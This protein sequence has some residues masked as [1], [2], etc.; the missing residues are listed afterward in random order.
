VA[1]NEFMSENL[2]QLNMTLKEIEY[3]REKN[4]AQELGISGTPAIAIFKNGD[5]IR[6]YL[7][8]LTT[9]ELSVMIREM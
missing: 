1:I 2:G 9:E 8:E 3:E 5:L 6:R 7:G 4:V